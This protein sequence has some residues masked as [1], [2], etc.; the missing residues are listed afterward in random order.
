[1]EQKALEAD[2][3]VIWQFLGHLT[4]DWDQFGEHQGVFEIRCLGENR[5]SLSERFALHAFTCFAPSF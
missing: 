3:S 4:Q 1:M 2:A 5:T